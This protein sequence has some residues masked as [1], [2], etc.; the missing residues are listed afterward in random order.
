M[1]TLKK[2]DIHRIGHTVFNKDGYASF[3]C[4][5]ITFNT[6]AIILAEILDIFGGYTITYEDDFINPDGSCDW[7]IETNLPFELFMNV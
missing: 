5:A 3:I 4:S 1:K 6:E 7:E 2:K